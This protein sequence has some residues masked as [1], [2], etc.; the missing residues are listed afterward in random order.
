V[1]QDASVLAVEVP[2]TVLERVTN[3]AGDAFVG[4]LAAELTT[5][6]SLDAA[7]ASGAAAVSRNAHV[8]A[9]VRSYPDFAR[10]GTLRR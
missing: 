7:A 6:S 3:G 2:A 1:I 5:G 9:A 10:E 8:S 4:V